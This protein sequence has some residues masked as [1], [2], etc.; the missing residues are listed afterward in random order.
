MKWEEMT[1]KRS[2][3]TSEEIMGGFDHSLLLLL[4]VIRTLAH[5]LGLTT[6]SRISWS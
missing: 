6:L 2:Q 5:P 1:N 3:G 4:V